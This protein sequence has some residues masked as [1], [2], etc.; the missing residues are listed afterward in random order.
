M[1]TAARHIPTFQY[2]TFFV[3]EWPGWKKG[4][5]G[6][7]FKKKWKLKVDLE[8]KQRKVVLKR[9]KRKASLTQNQTCLYLFFFKF[10]HVKCIMRD[11][12]TFSNML[13]FAREKA[14]LLK[15]W[16]P[17]HIVKMMECHDL[18][19][20]F[21]HIV[22]GKK[23]FLMSPY[24]FFSWSG[25]IS[26]LAVKYTFHNWS[27]VIITLFIIYYLWDY[28]IFTSLFLAIV[29]CFLDYKW[30]TVVNFFVTWLP[31]IFIFIFIFR[32]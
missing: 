24:L 14:R 10:R 29:C 31:L 22:S 9:K 30:L 5:P 3:V 6:R 4:V 1:C 16:L 23:G 21:A 20:V 27:V 13:L 11:N 2:I 32:V 15:G 8:I 28:L 12:L 19:L 17:C 25:Y 26:F 18:I 7:G